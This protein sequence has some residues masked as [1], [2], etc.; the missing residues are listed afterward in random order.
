[1]HEEPH[2][3]A[4]PTP[5][6]RVGIIGLGRVAWELELDPLRGKPC[7]HIGAWQS[8]PETQLVAGC[9]DEEERR[10]AFAEHYPGIRLYTDYQEMLERERIDLLSVC[11][12]ATERCEMVQAAAGAGVRGIWCEKAMAASLKEADAM[13]AALNAHDTALIVSFMRRWEPRYDKV[14]QLLEGGAIGALE[15]INVHFSGNMLHTGTHAFDVLHDWCGEVATVQAWLDSD[16]AHNGQSGYR[17]GSREMVEDFGGLA[18]LRFRNGIDAVIHGHSK[19]YFRF[20][21]E[22]LGSYGMIRIGNSQSELWTTAESQRYSDFAELEP[23]PFPTPAPR[24]PWAAAAADLVNATLH[25][26]R[27]RCGVDEGRHALAVALAM[28]HSHH[29]GNRPV[30][31]DETPAELYVPS[32]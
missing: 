12:Y 23:T 17:F 13:A 32:R 20:E 29:H 28:H 19:G 21:F 4:T 14:R 9:D 25:R 1:M 2:V 27:P 6:L 8:L 30:R 10:S 31:L 26:K 3:R 24:N 7:S 5:P 22:L 15:S 16:D 18:L 11:A